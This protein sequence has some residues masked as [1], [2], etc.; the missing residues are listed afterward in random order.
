MNRYNWLRDTNAR[1]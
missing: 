1:R